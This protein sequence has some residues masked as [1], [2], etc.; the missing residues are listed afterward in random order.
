MHQSVLVYLPSALQLPLPDL[1]LRDQLAPAMR[2]RQELLELPLLQVRGQL[3][4]TPGQLRVILQRLWNFIRRHAPRRAEAPPI[5]I[6][7]MK[8]L[9]AAHC[10]ATSRRLDLDTGKLRCL[11]ECATLSPRRTQDHWHGVSIRSALRM[12]RERWFV[13]GLGRA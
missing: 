4:R 10:V 7:A 12:R 8:F 9:M 13:T 6:A 2:L 11:K 1:P 3:R 5:S